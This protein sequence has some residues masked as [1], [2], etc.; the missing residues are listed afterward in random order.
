MSVP[1]APTGFTEPGEPIESAEPAESAEPSDHAPSANA[2]QASVKRSGLA[3]VVDEDF[4]VSEAVG[5]VRGAIESV[6]PGLAFVLVFVITRNL[7]LTVIIAAAI[8]L[9]S[10]VVRLIERQQVRSAL[11]GVLSIVVCLVWAW[12]SKDAKNFYLPGFLTNAFWILVLVVSLLVKIPGIGALVELIH[13]TIG[14]GVRTWLAS[15]RSDSKLVHAYVV[16]T[17]VW[18]GMFAARLLVQV[19]LY[20]GN[21]VGFLGTARLVMGVPLFALTIWISWVFI[22]P[23]IR[24]V[25]FEKTREGTAEKA[26]E[27]SMTGED[28]HD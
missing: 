8:S 26:D 28:V 14:D 23:Q 12:V 6:L 18:I 7:G 19:P 25:D 2:A 5:G 15:W 1:N 27:A 16:T 4:S 3:S 22:S 10:V 24:R 11:T 20:L 17:W 9:V 21:S 13:T